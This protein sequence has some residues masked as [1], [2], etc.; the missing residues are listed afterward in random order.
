MLK[1]LLVCLQKLASFLAYFCSFFSRRRKKEPH[2]KD[3]ACLPALRKPDPFIYSQY[4]LMSLGYPVTWDNP[5]I[6]IF[7]GTTLVNPHDLQASTTYT[8]AARIW[9]NSADTPVVNLK[10]TFSYLSFGMLTAPQSHPI[11]TK[12]TD[13]QVKGLPPAFPWISWTTP[14]APGHYCLQ[15]LLEPPDDL[16]WL[17]NLGQ[18]NTDVT[19]A[20]SPANFTFTVGNPDDARPSTVAFT[21]DTYAIPPLPRCDEREPGPTRVR[22]ISKTPPPV[23]PGWTVAITPNQ[24]QLAPGEETTV[25]VAITP[26]TAFTGTMPFNITAWNNIHPI[27]GVTLYVE[28]P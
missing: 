8:V 17:N 20:A 5:D 13:L 21:V 19:H 6:F 4:Y 27:G 3:H 2:C 16:N 1:K 15:V 12:T 11:G 18:R 7:D 28:V 24:L 14:A 10:V 22:T 25:Q 26:P 23:P 9:N